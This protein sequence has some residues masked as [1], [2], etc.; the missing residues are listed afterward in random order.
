MSERNENEKAAASFD[1]Q[2]TALMKSAKK[3]NEQLWPGVVGQL[4]MAQ[5][6]VRSMMH[7]DDAAKAR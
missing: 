7:P 4:E 2:L 3:R 1:V 5:H 6:H